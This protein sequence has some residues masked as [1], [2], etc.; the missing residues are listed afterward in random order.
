VENSFR[1][2]IAEAYFNRFAPEGWRAISAGLIPAE[3]IHPNAVKLM[4]EEGM[5]IGWKRPRRLTRD[6]Q[7]RADIVVVVCS[8][9]SC[10][11]IYAE[12]IEKWDIPDPARMSLDEARKIRDIIKG[13][14]LSL[15]ER[16]KYK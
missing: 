2:Q 12:N 7:E 10:P 5:D 14:V 13:R 15:I 6:L 3:S 16:I 1:S 9:V 4:L 11:V 8:N